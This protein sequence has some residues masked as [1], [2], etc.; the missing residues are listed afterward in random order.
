MLVVYPDYINP[1][2]FCI[3]C[4]ISSTLCA[5]ESAI[6]TL[7]SEFKTFAGKDGSSDTLSKE[8]F[9]SLVACQLPNFVQNSSDPAVIDQLMGS[10][11]ENNDGELTFL[12]FWQ[13]IGRL[14]N[15]HGG[16]SQ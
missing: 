3:S 4:S 14:A 1:N 5:M 15:K 13:L 10:L 16:F 8:E 7:V 2:L 6:N 12:E 9:R 11:D